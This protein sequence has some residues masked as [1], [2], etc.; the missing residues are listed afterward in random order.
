MDFIYCRNR[1]TLDHHYSLSLDLFIDVS[2]SDC[3]PWPYSLSLDHHY[4]LSLLCIVLLTWCDAQMISIPADSNNLF[5][6]HGMDFI[7]W[8]L[9]FDRNRWSPLLFLSISFVSF[10]IVVW[11]TNDI[12][13]SCQQQ[14]I[15]FAWHGLYL[16]TFQLVTATLDHRYFLSI[17]FVSFY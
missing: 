7:Y 3:N 6:L 16:L 11:W 8:R 1:S 2:A 5:I 14:L 9:I 12:D 13:T 15:Y 10:Y 17:S 4:S